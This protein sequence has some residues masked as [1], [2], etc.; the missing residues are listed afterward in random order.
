MR[1][2]KNMKQG[3]VVEVNGLDTE[4]MVETVEAIKNNPS[5]GMFE[6]RAQNQWIN[7]GENRSCIQGFY[8]AGAEDQS[9]DEP[10]VFTNGEPPVLLGNNEGANPVEFLLHALAGCVTTTMHVVIKLS[11]GDMNCTLTLPG[12]SARS[13]IRCSSN[14]TIAG[15]ERM[16]STF[17]ALFALHAEGKIKPVIFDTYS[18]EDVPVALGALA[19]RK[20]YGKVIVAP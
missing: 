19:S 8:G 10:F 5:L 15:L 3:V 18:L 13:S 16:T 6:F 4:K 1:T 7:G 20:T 11:S 2:N 12:L 9:R 17:D 14:V